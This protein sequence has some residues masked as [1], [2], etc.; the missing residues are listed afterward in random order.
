MSEVKRYVHNEDA[1]YLAGPADDAADTQTYVEYE[2]F[3]AERTAKEAALAERDDWKS[4]CDLAQREWA[5]ADNKAAALEAELRKVREGVERLSNDIHLMVAQGE[6]PDGDG[7]TVNVQ[8]WAEK[9][10]PRLRTLLRG[11]EEKSNAQ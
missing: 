9:W 8:L 5:A 10:A 3:T 4:A 1:M 7:L 11:C 2:D 6:T